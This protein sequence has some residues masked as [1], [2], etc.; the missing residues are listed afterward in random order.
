MPRHHSSAQPLNHP[1]HREAFF[2]RVPF[3]I[4]SFNAGCRKAA[5]ASHI[6]HTFWTHHTPTAMCHNS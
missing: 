4:Q 3:S 6:P 2:K 1:M 5:S